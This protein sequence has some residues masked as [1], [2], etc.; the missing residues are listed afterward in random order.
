MFAG[1]ITNFAKSVVLG[2]LR[3]Y[4]PAIGGALTV[5]GVADKVDATSLEGSIYYL[6]N[7]AF[8]VVPA[9]FSYLQ[10]KGVQSL[11]TSAIAAAP[12]SAEAAAI[13]AK[14]S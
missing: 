5:M 10:K 2:Q 3:A 8:V 12:G 9:I 6:A 1:L 4:L 7:A 14:V 13:V 11:V